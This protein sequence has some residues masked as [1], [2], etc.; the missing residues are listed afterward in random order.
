MGGA[1]RGV[2]PTMVEVK[3][4]LDGGRQEFTCRL[5]AR[6]AAGVVLLY[7]TRRAWPVAPD[8]T[9]PPGTHSVAYYW[10]GRP[11]NAYHWRTPAGTTLGLY[12]NLSDRTRIVADRLLWRDLVVDL[13]VTPDGRCRVLDEEELPP[14]LD[15]ALRR[16]IE[17]ARDAVL[18]GHPVLLAEVERRSAELLRTQAEAEMG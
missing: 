6:T 12:V 4:R 3:E 5:L 13:L 10:P 16:R 14:D 1:V 17:A 18:A 2:L 15:P 11:Y 8:L 7:E 9:V